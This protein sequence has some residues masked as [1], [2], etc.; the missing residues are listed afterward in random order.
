MLWLVRGRDSSPAVMAPKRGSL[1]AATG[2]GKKRGR[3]LSLSHTTAKDMSVR[4]RSPKLHILRASS[5]ATPTVCRAHSV[6][7][8]ARSR[9]GAPILLPQGQLS[10]DTQEWTGVSS[11][12]PS[13]ISTSQS[14]SP[15][16]DILLILGNRC[17]ATAEPQI[18]HRPGPHHGPWWHHWLL[19]SG[20]SSL[21]ARPLFIVSTSF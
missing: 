7:Q 21:P 18:Q 1:P 19:T 9:V 4:A 10:R 6:R 5:S 2:K 20:C 13:D 16:Q 17:P 15:D 8:Q 14:S 12:Q 3:Y 11:A